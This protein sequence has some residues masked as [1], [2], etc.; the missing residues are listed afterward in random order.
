MLQFVRLARLPLMAPVATNFVLS[1]IIRILLG[2]VLLVCLVLGAGWSY[3]KLAEARDARRYPAPGVMVDVGGYRL[4]LFCEG[5]GSPTVVVRVGGGEPAL[6]FRPVQDQIAQVTRVCAYDPAGVGW[7]DPSPKAAETF[8]DRSAAL[9]TLLKNG[10]VPGPYVLV[11]HSYGGLVVRLFARD[12]L[13]DV[14]GAVLV[15]AAEE[16]EVFGTAWSSIFAAGLRGGKQREN[17]ARF[18]VRRYQLSKGTE[19]FGLRPDLFADMRGDLLSFIVR[20]CACDGGRGGFVLRRSCRN[21]GPGW[22]WETR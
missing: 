8:E 17:L 11:A 10:K 6:M 20:L 1:W 9:A 12:H 7:S 4:D 13:S 14:S 3:E 21:A 16:G 18:G 5:A 15:D 2:S 22:I 19:L